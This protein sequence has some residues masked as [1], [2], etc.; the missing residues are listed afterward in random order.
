M[1][2]HQEIDT[3]VA[4]ETMK[5]TLAQIADSL[6]EI[7]AAVAEQTKQ[8]TNIEARLLQMETDNSKK[9][10]SMKDD[11]MRE[12]SAM[13]E[14]AIRGIKEDLEADYTKR[15]Q[16]AIDDG[17]REIKAAVDNSAAINGAH[18]A[19]RD[20]IM[21]ENIDTAMQTLQGNMQTLNDNMRKDMN[22][23]HDFLQSG[24]RR[25]RDAFQAQLNMV[26]KRVADMEQD[27]KNDTEEEA[28]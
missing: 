6:M 12:T 14:S 2:G 28:D 16:A 3:Q 4:D 8:T 11:I 5:N 26:E 15:I 21:K 13:M 9:M 27:L 7:R 19:A 20:V 18:V 22:S 10:Q 24:C 23:L 1:G 25:R 17:D